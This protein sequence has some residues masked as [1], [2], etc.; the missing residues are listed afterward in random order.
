MSDD[1]KVILDGEVKGVGS[2]SL[3]FSDRDLYLTVPIDVPGGLSGE[4]KLKLDPEALIDK[5]AEAIPGTL[6]D[7]VLGIVKAAFFEDG[8][9]G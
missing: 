1:K 5:L 2:Y 9:G 6:D 8:E 3:V 4:I 7:S